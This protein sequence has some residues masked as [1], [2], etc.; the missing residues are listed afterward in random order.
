M[1]SETEILEA[2]AILRKP[3]PTAK[4]VDRL[5]ELANRFATDNTNAIEKV[6]W[7]EVPKDIRDDYSKEAEFKAWCTANGV[8]YY[9]RPAESFSPREARKLCAAAGLKRLLTENLS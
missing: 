3:L 2:I 8:Y 5:V 1:L 7:E 6:S 9:A 4:E